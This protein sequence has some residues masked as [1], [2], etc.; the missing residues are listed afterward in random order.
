MRCQGLILT[1]AD[2]SVKYS[3]VYILSTSG[4]EV[5]L[6]DPFP[7]TAAKDKK[8]DSDDNSHHDSEGHVQVPCIPETQ[9]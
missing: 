2:V 6:L 8:Q 5:H 3:Y 1:K 9:Q 4:P 7:D